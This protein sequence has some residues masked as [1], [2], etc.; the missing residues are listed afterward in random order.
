LFS[1]FLFP[2]PGRLTIP[3]AVFHRRRIDDG[4]L[5]RIVRGKRQTDFISIPVFIF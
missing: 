5:Q 3:D 1:K 4:L 2:P